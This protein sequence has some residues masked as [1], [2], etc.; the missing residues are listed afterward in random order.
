MII[1]VFGLYL[2]CTSV[3]YCNGAFCQQLNVDREDTENINDEFYG[4]YCNDEY[5]QAVQNLDIDLSSFIDK[6]AKSKTQTG[7][8]LRVINVFQKIFRIPSTYLSDWLH[9]LNL[10]NEY[11]SLPLSPHLQLVQ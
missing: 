2:Y 8:T 10:K 4:E 11:K 9:L 7:S 6:V 1:V 5:D 3:Q